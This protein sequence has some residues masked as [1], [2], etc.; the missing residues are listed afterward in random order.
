MR[1]SSAAC[2]RRFHMTRDRLDGL[3][4][5]LEDDDL[6]AMEMNELADM[7]ELQ[8]EYRALAVRQLMLGSLLRDLLFDDDTAGATLFDEPSRPMG[9]EDCLDPLLPSTSFNGQSG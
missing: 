2:V 1:A 5:K 8:P 6:T 9:E 4:A 7:L 3:L